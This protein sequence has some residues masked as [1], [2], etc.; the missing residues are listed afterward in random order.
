MLTVNSRGKCVALAMLAAALLNG[1]GGGEEIN[2]D[3][4]P[5]VVDYSKRKALVIGVDGVQY[6]KLQEAIAAGQAPNMARF[7]L[8]K[9]YG[10]GIVGSVTEQV[11]SSGAS[12][13]TILTGVWANRHKVVNNDDKLRNQADSVFKLIKD[14]DARRRTASIV[15]W[16]TINNNF[17]RDIDLR[18]V[19]HAEKCS[20]DDQCVADKVSGL[21]VFG[22]VDFVFAHFDDVDN[23]GHSVGF[24]PAYQAAIQSTD[25]RIGQ[26]LAALQRRQQAHPDEDWLIMVT[27]DHGRSLPGGFGHGSQTLSEKTTFI[28]INKEANAQFGSPFKDPADMAF[29]GLYGNATQADIVP[30]VLTHLGVKPDVPNYRIDGVPLL[31]QPSVRQLTAKADGETRSVTLQWRNSGQPSGKPLTIY[32]DGKQIAQLDDAATTYVDQGLEIPDGVSELNYSVVLDQ[33]PAAYLARINAGKPA[34]PNP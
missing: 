14:A 9:T 2:V 26:V 30:T 5:P 29:N 13:T 4:A 24:V 7:H 25:A 27:P 10:G 11:T 17:A 1:C 22:D 32:R 18:Y 28:A 6:E 23:V 34:R 8:A 16:N 12:W 31:G 3:P 19:T 20:E 33:V 15:S 21:L